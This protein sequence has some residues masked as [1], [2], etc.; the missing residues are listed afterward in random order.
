VTRPHLLPR[1]IVNKAEALVT[2]TAYR[3]R[4]KPGR[5]IEDLCFSFYNS[6]TLLF[7]ETDGR[8]YGGGVLEVTP[9]E[10]KNLPLVFVEPKKVEYAKF[11]KAV[12][13]ELRTPSEYFSFGDDW[14]K[15]KMQFSHEEMM[16]LQDALMTVRSH[17]LRHGVIA[18]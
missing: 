17:R 16:M 11:K 15:Q 6:L 3:I 5:N 12:E 9:N 4:M 8:F 14:L 1:I 13:R 10:F 2:D 7:A 18:N